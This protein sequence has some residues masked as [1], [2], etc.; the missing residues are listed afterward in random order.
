[1]SKTS[2]AVAKSSHK[3]D[4]ASKGE[5]RDIEKAIKRIHLL[6][7]IGQASLKSDPGVMPSGAVIEHK[8][9]R[10]RSTKLR[11][12]RAFAT[13]V[14][15]DELQEILSKF[16]G[17]RRAIGETSMLYVVGIDS[18]TDRLQ[19]L[20]KALESKWSARRLQAAAS[21][22]LTKKPVANVGREPVI[23]QDLRLRKQ[24]LSAVCFSFSRHCKLVI[25]ANKGRSRLPK[26]IINEIAS[27]RDAVKRLRNLVDDRKKYDDDE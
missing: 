9:E 26:D 14:S 15:D 6:H 25:K 3:R 12:L 10:F 20:D 1:M 17:Y 22:Y 16:R 11:K 2:R 13:V 18:Q 27:V 24:Q 4:H 7:S 5:L 8:G 21:Q 19:L 23:E